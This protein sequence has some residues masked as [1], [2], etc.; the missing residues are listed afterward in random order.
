MSGYSLLSAL[1]LRINSAVILPA[2]TL[3]LTNDYAIV[4]KM[5]ESNTSKDQ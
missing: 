2:P 1:T 4:L 3:A 5:S